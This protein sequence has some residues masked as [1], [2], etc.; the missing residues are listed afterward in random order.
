MFNFEKIVSLNKANLWT[1][2]ADSKKINEYC[3]FL[4]P[5]AYTFLNVRQKYILWITIFSLSLTA[6]WK[7]RHSKVHDMKYAKIPSTLNF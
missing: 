4:E 6:D 5:L 7:S 3:M 1:V 2:I